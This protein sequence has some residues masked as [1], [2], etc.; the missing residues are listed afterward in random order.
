MSELITD[1][2]LDDTII[3]SE[4]LNR[5]YKQ[6]EN[7]FN[8]P[9]FIGINGSK[10]IHLSFREIYS[11]FN[12]VWLIYTHTSN[13][14]ISKIFDKDA[15]IESLK[16]LNIYCGLIP[17]TLDIIRNLN[18]RHKSCI[19]DRDILIQ[20][21][22]EKELNTEFNTSEIIIPLVELDRNNCELLRNINENSHNL[23]EIEKILSLIMTYNRSYLKDVINQ[24]E[25]TLY[26]TTISEYWMNPKNCRLNMTEFFDK[27]GF[28][29]TKEDKRK[30]NIQNCDIIYKELINN[31][32]IVDTNDINELINIQPNGYFDIRRQVNN[33]NTSLYE[34]LKNTKNRTYYITEHNQINYDK[35]K[36]IIKLAKEDTLFYHVFNNILVSKEYSHL[37]L[38]DVDILKRGSKL[39]DKYLP[40]YKTLFGYAWLNMILNESIMRTYVKETDNIVFDINTASNLPVFPFLTDDTTQNPY[41]IFL[42]DQMRQLNKSKS[43]SLMCPTNYE[44]YYG[45]CSISEFEERLKVFITSSDIDIFK[46][47][48][49]NYYAITGSVIPACLQRLSPLIELSDNN[50]VKY[51]DTYYKDSDLDIVCNANDIYEFCEKTNDLSQIIESN[52]D[53]ILNI[54]PIKV[55]SIYITKHFFIE[56]LD[57]YNEYSN[58]ELELEEFIKLA[59]TEEF[60]KFIHSIYIENK[61]IINTKINNANLNKNK[62]IEHHMIPV[63]YDELNIYVELTNYVFD[64][65]KSKKSDTA[66]SIFINDIRENEDKVSEQNNYLCIKICEIVR[67]KLSCDKMRTPIEIFKSYGKEFFSTVSRF[68]LPCVRAYYRNNNV[69]MLPSCI[70]AMMTGVN[71]DYRYF[72]SSR[73]PIDIINKYVRRG[74]GILLSQKEQEDVIKYNASNTE[75][76]NEYKTKEYFSGKEITNNIYQSNQINLNINYIKNIDDMKKYYKEKYNY[77]PSIFGFDLYVLK[78]INDNG[79][80]MP[81]QPWLSSTYKNMLDESLN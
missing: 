2:V 49:W 71:I 18:F 28:Y 36:S 32:E 12:R 14:S 30:E 73:N 43:M 4:Y 58:S 21:F 19:I 52:L 59:L 74:Y 48:D 46:N 31:D 54:E 40:L 72:A 9:F 10:L 5:P 8:N 80:I 33:L 34:S 53:T 38:K 16:K 65:D 42:V 81:L 25:L 3:Y 64:L 60:N 35:I 57:K 61:N 63:S 23:D 44:K 24:V 51:F 79:Y 75:L 69:Y 77:D 11:K 45:I 76:I 62:F 27:R 41:I 7:K 47:L 55:I 6:M 68:H 22:N 15:D 39:F 56:Y 20:I 26:K 66:I 13:Q 1:I 37:I 50:L 17:T 70:T 67:F 29:S 78:T